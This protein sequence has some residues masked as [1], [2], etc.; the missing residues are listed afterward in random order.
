MEDFPETVAA[1]DLGSNS[2]HLIVAQVNEQGVLQKVD[3]LEEMVSGFSNNTVEEMVK[4]TIRR[5]HEHAG[6]APQSDDITVLS[7]RM[8]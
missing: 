6:S 1:V 5:V 3:K 2:F 8:T 7:L 4:E